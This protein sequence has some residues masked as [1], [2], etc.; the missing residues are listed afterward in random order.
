MNTPII[1][2]DGFREMAQA[3]RVLIRNQCVT[4]GVETVAGMISVVS[5][6]LM[7]GQVFIFDI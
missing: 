7:N 2:I 4:L 1:L 3:C 5:V 6:G